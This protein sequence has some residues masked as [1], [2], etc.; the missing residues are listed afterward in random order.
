[1]DRN[2]D[3]YWAKKDG[4]EEGKKEGKKEGRTEGR[5][6]KQ[7]EIAKKLI[8]LKMSVEQIIEITELTEEEVKSIQ[9]N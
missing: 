2:S 9:E 7:I 3:I 8:N 5:K 4:I 1:M 6:S